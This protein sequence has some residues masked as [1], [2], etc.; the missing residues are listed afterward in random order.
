MKKQNDIA[1]V[2]NEKV[3]DWTSFLDKDF[4]DPYVNFKNNISLELKD[5]ILKVEQELLNASIGYTPEIARK[6]AICLV[7]EQMLVIQH[8]NI[9]SSL[10]AMVVSLFAQLPG[11]KNFRIDF[12]EKS[13]KAGME[14]QKKS[15]KMFWKNFMNGF[16]KFF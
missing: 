15:G 16:Y 2:D 6:M 8:E 14:E 1:D 10:D 5:V 12:Y 13:V 9:P 7:M 4:K 11:V 3:W